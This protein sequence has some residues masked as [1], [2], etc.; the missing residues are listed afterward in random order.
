MSNETLV[1][2]HKAIIQ[3]KTTIIAT[4]TKT[5]I[6]AKRKITHKVNYVYI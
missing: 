2:W 3:K 1:T 4:L 6:I 5:T